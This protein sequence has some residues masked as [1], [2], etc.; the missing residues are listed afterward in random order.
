MFPAAASLTPDRKLLSS[1]VL[2]AILSAPTSGFFFSSE[3]VQEPK[4]PGSLSTVRLFVSESLA[5]ARR[6]LDS[7]LGREVVE[8]SLGYF[9][10]VVFTVSEGAATGLNVLVKL[11]SELLTALG[12]EDRHSLARLQFTHQEVATVLIWTLAALIGYWLLSLALRLVGCVVRRVLWLIK[13]AAFSGTFLL[14]VRRVEDSYQRGA[15]VLGLVLL[16]VL[17]GGFRGSAGETSAAR[18]EGLEQRVAELNRKV[19]SQ[20]K[21]IRKEEN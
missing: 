14:I 18:L 12:V 2:L 10:N 16:A 17:L 21:R 5:E 7:W 6:S 4:K 20:S 3:P 9:Q 15:L 13:L 19:N 8:T 1:L 11:I